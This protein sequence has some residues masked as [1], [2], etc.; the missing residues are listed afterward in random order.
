[1]LNLLSEILGS[2]ILQV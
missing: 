1:M 2:L